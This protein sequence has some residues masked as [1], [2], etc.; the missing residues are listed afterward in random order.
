MAILFPHE[1]ANKPH[2]HLCGPLNLCVSCSLTLPSHKTCFHSP[3]SSF[4]GHG[5]GFLFNWP[6]Q[7]GTKPFCNHFSGKRNLSGWIW[8]CHSFFTDPFWVPIALS[9][10]QKLP[11][12]LGSAWLAS[13]FI[14]NSLPVSHPLWSRHTM[15]IWSCE[16]PMHS[17]TSRQWNLLFFL[18]RILLLP[19][20][21]LQWLLLVSFRLQMGQHHLF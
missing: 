7:Q 6:L 20:H 1:Y 18:P 19:T 3:I 9:L 14:I 4:M 12:I 15:F 10:K 11:R 17:L 8:S 5:I 2:P 16:H 13:A 21:T